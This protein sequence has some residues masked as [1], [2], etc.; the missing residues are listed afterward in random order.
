MSSF[1]SSHPIPCNN[2][3]ATQTICPNISH[4]HVALER[5][6]TAPVPTA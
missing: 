1:R 3:K 2:G 5:P 6:G 4:G